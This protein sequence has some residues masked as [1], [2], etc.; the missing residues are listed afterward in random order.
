MGLDVEKQLKQYLQNE[1]LVFFEQTVI[2]NEAVRFLESRN[3]EKHNL[4][5]WQDIYNNVYGEFCGIPIKVSTIHGVKGETHKATLY[6]ETKFRY[7]DLEEMI[8]HLTGS[9][10]KG[11]EDLSEQR[12]KMVYVGMS[13]AS[14]LLCMA[15]RIG[16]VDDTQLEALKNMGIQIKYIYS[17]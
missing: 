16:A 12:Q 1:L 5:K 3:E 8:K 2:T 17:D 11:G 13:R 4:A 6:L 9:E 14:H 15:I 7:F 10:M